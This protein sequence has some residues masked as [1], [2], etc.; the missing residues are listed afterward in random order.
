MGLEKEW[1]REREAKGCQIV[2]V[3]VCVWWG[4]G[5]VCVDAQEGEGLSEICNASI[6]SVVVLL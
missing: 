3:C 4:G 5:V 6:N 2:Y 1:E